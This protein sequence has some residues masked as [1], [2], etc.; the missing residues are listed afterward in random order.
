MWWFLYFFLHKAWSRK[1]A[2]IFTN[3]IIS[4][5]PKIKLRQ[6]LVGPQSSELP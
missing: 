5:T 1:P 6:L 3:Y 4:R 2:M